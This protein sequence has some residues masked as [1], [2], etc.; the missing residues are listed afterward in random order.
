M[1]IGGKRVR[2]LGPQ[3]REGRNL[4]RQNL[5][6]QPRILRRVV[7]MPDLK[8]PVLIMLDQMVVG[9]PRKGQRIQP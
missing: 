5:Q 3:S 4:V 7:H 6:G 9:A 8:P 1:V 2:R